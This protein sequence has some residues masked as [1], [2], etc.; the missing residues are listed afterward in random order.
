MMP[1]TIDA[2]TFPLIERIKALE[3]QLVNSRIEHS[4]TMHG[5][6]TLR[7]EL[8]AARNELDQ[9]NNQIRSLIEQNCDLS[10]RLNGGPVLQR[11][12]VEAMTELESRKSVGIM[13]IGH[14]WHFLAGWWRGKGWHKRPGCGVM[15]SSMNRPT[16]GWFIDLSTIPEVQ[17]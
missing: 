6:D 16:A 17:Q 15:A 4:H 2:I 9:A 11:V 3:T 1:T 7:T 14:E 10:N 8:D 5:R 13:M 12:T